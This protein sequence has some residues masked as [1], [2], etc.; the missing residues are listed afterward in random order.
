MPVF[1]QDLDA[2]KEFKYA[3][4]TWGLA[5]SVLLAILIIVLLS[6]IVLVRWLKPKFDEAFAE[7]VALVKSM[8]AAVPVM[9]QG[10]E[11]LT[12]GIKK[13]ETSTDESVRELKH[14]TASINKQS[15]ILED[16]SDKLNKWP[17]DVDKVCKARH[18]LAEAGFSEKT[19]SRLF[20]LL[21]RHGSSKKPKKDG[22][23]H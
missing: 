10:I 21:E 23:A 2:V 7:H 5:N 20:A 9:R 3:A 6:L 11:M 17:S 22:G 1:A 8:N 19:I 18:A 14:Q 4:E 12:G 15:V 13:L 16:M